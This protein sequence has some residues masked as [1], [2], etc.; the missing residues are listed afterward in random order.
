MPP[1]ALILATVA[2]DGYA[3][4][5][6]L[7]VSVL[8]DGRV[9]A[10]RV[11]SHHET[12]G[13]GDKI[14]EAKSDWIDGFSGTSLADPDLEH[15]AV[16]RDG[17]RFDQFTGATITPRALVR[18]VRNTLLFVR[19]EGERLYTAPSLSQEPHEAP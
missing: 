8:P 1:E 11:L 13:M 9:G 4:P 7:L 15:W 19:S 18:A 6:E 14:E 16:R 2:T 10:V 17:G 5:V 3:G 12:P